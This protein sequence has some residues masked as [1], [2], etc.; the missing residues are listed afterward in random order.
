M[1]HP[2]AIG[3]LHAP[4]RLYGRR[5]MMRPLVPSDH[6]DWSG[7]RRSNEDW[8][9]RGSRSGPPANPTSPATAP[10]SPPDARPAIATAR[11]TPPTH[12]ACSSTS[13]SR[14]RSISTTSCAA[15]SSRGTV[16][17]WI[18]RGRAGQ[19]Y[20]AEGVVVLARF[21]F[22]QLQLHRL[23]VC[24]VPRN[25]NSRRVMEKL[26][27]RCEGLSEK[28]LEIAGVWEDHLRFAITVE[29]WETRRDELTGAWL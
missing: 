14:A 16:G 13:G 15:R 18:D 2:S 23:E 29:D 19:G 3:R 26:G 8:L 9:S 17:Y 25:T 7:V 4:L 6:S 20:V 21:A 27:L 12:S 1:R 22:E 24:I 28:Y 5:V 10:R 11:P